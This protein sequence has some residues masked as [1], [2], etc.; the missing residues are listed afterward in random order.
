MSSTWL[1]LLHPTAEATHE[2]FNRSSLIAQWTVS[3]P[4]LEATYAQAL[5][6]EVE[7]SLHTHT[8]LSMFTYSR[9]TCL[10]MLTHYK[11]VTLSVSCTHTTHTHNVHKH[12]HTHTVIWWLWMLMSCF[13]VYP[14]RMAWVAG[15]QPPPAFN[16][17]YLAHIWRVK[18]RRGWHFRG[19]VWLN[20]RCLGWGREGIKQISPQISTW[21]QETAFVNG[22]N[23]TGGL[24]LC[25]VSF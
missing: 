5:M 10:H 22:R 17:V 2:S 15:G 25:C 24:C 18:E 20:G 16:D 14:T 13:G 4:S 19:C 21:Y 12:T 9:C 8:I 3:P 1:N 6:H 11:V 23:M 7:L